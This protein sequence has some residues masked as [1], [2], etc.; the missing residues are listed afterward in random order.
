MFAWHQLDSTASQL[1]EQDGEGA[2]KPEGYPATKDVLESGM[3]LYVLQAIA[4]AIRK[5]QGIAHQ[6]IAQGAIVDKTNSTALQTRD[7]N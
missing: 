7:W 3:L 1:A 5:H 4:A 2:R 6:S